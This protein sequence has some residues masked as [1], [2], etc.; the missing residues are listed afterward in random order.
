MSATTQQLLT[1]QDVADRLSLDLKTVRRH[2]R[3]GEYDAFALN[4]GSAQ[5]PTW[6]YDPARL[7]KW[8]DTRRAA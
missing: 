5:R 8:L 2:T 7:E 4:I 3:R 1:A 6:R